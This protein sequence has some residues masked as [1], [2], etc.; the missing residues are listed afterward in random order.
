MAHIL[1]CL[2][3]W[4]DANNQP[5]GPSP[6]WYCTAGAFDAAAD[7]RHTRQFIYYDDSPV[8]PLDDALIGQC[9]TTDFL[10][11]PVDL[12]F[13]TALVQLGERNVKPETYGYIRDELKTP[14]I[15]LWLESAPDVVRVADLYA[16]YVTANIFVDTKE[17]WKKFTKFQDKTFWV[18]EPKD[19]RIFFTNDEPRVHRVT[20]AGSVVGRL[21][22]ALNIGWLQGHGVE[23]VKRG[24]SAEGGLDILQYADFLR[25]SAITLNFTSAITFQHVNARTSEATMSGALLMES[26]SAETANL[27]D[28]FVHY[29][30]FKETFHI[31]E[32]SGQMVIDQHGDLVDKVR[33][34]LSDKGQAERAKIARQGAAR[35]KE[36][37]DGSKFWAKIFELAGLAW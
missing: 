10:F 19:P 35:A 1:F 20:C 25:Q 27:L 31:D 17:Y 9:C 8:S 37:F 7:R 28:P 4:L 13:A 5:L 32:A 24:G 18:P 3:A 36:L 16:P 15:M 21:D 2:E 22:R 6:H 23:V 34:Y 14:V 12:V 26:E 29:V 33:F 11:K 30:P